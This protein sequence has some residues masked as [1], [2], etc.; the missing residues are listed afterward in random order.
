[1]KRFF[2]LT[3]LF[4]LSGVGRAAAPAVHGMVLFGQERLFASH[5]PMYHAPHDFQV[6]LEVGLSHATED[7]VAAYRAKGMV[8]GVQRLITLRPKPFVLPDLLAGKVQEISATL[9]DGNFEAGGRPFLSAVK[10]TVKQIL[11][12]RHLSEGLPVL[13]ELTYLPLPGYLVHLISAPDNFDHI[14]QVSGGMAEEPEAIP[15]SFLAT[16]DALDTR[17]VAGQIFT[18]SGGKAHFIPATLK[19]AGKF[20]VSHAFYCTLGPDFA[21]ACD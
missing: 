6:I 7:A 15:V 16:P 17:L 20:T 18:V 1:M 3:S 21:Q 12:Q 10:V 4:F 14:V 13:N 8:E 2:L 5:V 9:Y 11:F 19:A